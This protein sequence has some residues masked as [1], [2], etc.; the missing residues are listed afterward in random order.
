MTIVATL[1]SA[2]PP[3]V[4]RQIPCLDSIPNFPIAMNELIW[5]NFQHYCILSASYCSSVVLTKLY[6]FPVNIML[7]M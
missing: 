1:N 4:S 7:F 2:V 5:A 3:T 6:V